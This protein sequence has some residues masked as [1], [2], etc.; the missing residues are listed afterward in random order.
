VRVARARE[1]LD[2]R[3][4]VVAELLQFIHDFN[5]LDT[6]A[7]I[8]KVHADQKF[9]E[10]AEAVLL[11]AV[12]PW[13]SVDALRD[14]AVQNLYGEKPSPESLA[15][16][17]RPGRVSPFSVPYALL[18]AMAPNPGQFDP[19]QL[20]SLSVA[21]ALQSN[22]Y[23]GE[24]QRWDVRAPG[25][26]VWLVTTMWARTIPKKSTV[27]KVRVVDQGSNRILH[28][29]KLWA[30]IDDPMPCFWWLPPHTPLEITITR[31]REE[32]PIEVLFAI[33]GWRYLRG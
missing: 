16:R 17:I 24:E 3:R 12:G 14:F 7:L 13:K 33:E 20:R 18:R 27:T 23:A 4:E 8:E 2:E 25:S 6:T 31:Q 15:E 10:A 32:A 1:T 9:L 30:M 11:A 21:E 29:G 26:E 22:G 28:E 5:R 19:H